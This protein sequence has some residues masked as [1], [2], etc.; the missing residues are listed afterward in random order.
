[1]VVA[2]NGRDVWRLFDYYLAHGFVDEGR[3]LISR[4]L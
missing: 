4:P 3:R 1:L 2:P